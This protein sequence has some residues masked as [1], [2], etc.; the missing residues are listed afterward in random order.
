MGFG[1]GVTMEVPGTAA[2]LLHE[3]RH[4]IAH[5]LDEGTTTP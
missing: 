2:V 4:E 1:V 3:P 5:G